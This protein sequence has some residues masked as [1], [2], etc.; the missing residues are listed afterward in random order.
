MISFALLPLLP[1]GQAGSI[2]HLHENCMPFDFPDL[3]VKNKHLGVTSWLIDHGAQPDVKDKV[4]V[5][6]VAVMCGHLMH[7]MRIGMGINVSK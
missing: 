4:R 2:P 7:L 5:Q 3:A 1:T 6:G